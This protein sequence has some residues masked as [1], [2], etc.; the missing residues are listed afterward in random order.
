VITP[1]SSFAFILK[2]SWNWC[3]FVK[4]ILLNRACESIN[5]FS[6]NPKSNVKTPLTFCWGTQR[7]A[8]SRFWSPEICHP[9]SYTVDYYTLNRCQRDVPT[10]CLCSYIFVHMGLSFLPCIHL[11][12]RRNQRVNLTRSE[13][14]TINFSVICKNKQ[15]FWAF[16]SSALPS[17]CT[18]WSRVHLKGAV[19]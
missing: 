17:L 18:A 8:N 3:S 5:F 11:S 10:V 4:I 9:C 2:N 1:T 7:N 12:L 19:C 14:S 16:L 15:M 13:Y 6:H